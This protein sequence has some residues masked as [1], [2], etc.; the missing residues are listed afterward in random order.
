MKT[1]VEAVE[2]L[3]PL[4]VDEILDRMVREGIKFK[5]TYDKPL[6]EECPLARLFQHMTGNPNIR[7][8]LW[9]TYDNEYRDG[10]HSLTGGL[11]EFRK[12]FDYFADF[13]RR[14]KE[15]IGG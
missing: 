5:R 7:V 4:S 6:N 3:A 9:E 12:S 11:A 15:A 10:K 1:L 8:G 2:E 14:V 13:E